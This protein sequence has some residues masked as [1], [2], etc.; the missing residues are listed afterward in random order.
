MDESPTLFGI[1]ESIQL[2]CVE[3]DTILKV[4]AGGESVAKIESVSHVDT[5][6]LD[7]INDY[8]V[9]ERRKGK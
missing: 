8:R 7:G 6:D 5:I 3:R 9:R 1:G 4:R 2:L